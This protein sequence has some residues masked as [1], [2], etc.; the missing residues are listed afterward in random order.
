M[1]GNRSILNLLLMLMLFVSCKKSDIAYENDVDRSYR[2]WINFR[3]SS[4]NSYRY[5]VKTTSWTGTTSQTVITVKNG[6]ANQRSY[7]Y[8]I[9][10]PQNYLE[11]TIREQWD[12]NLTSL[13]SH[14]NGFP[15]LTLDE[16]YQKAKT[17]WL[18]KRDNAETFFEAKNNGMLSTAGYI[19]NNCADDCFNGVSISSIEKLE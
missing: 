9:Q 13:N 8:Q 7:V 18:L 6:R 11:L 14:T 12:E 17:D 16:I 5:T 4:R 3:N 15:P 10:S 2:T 19:E 1:K